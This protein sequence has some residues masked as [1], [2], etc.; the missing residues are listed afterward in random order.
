MPTADTRASI[1][2]LRALPDRNRHQRRALRAILRTQPAALQCDDLATTAHDIACGLLEARGQVL[3]AAHRGV[4][5]T[6]VGQMACQLMLKPDLVGMPA[7][8][9][10]GKT[11]SIVGFAAGLHRCGL[12]HGRPFLGKSVLITAFKIEALVEL[13]ND[14][15][16]LGVPAD[17]VGIMFDKDEFKKKD[18]IDRSGWPLPTDDP[19]RCPILLVTHNRVTGTKGD[20]DRAAPF[21]KFAG[22]DRDLVIVDE[23]LSAFRA[24]AFEAGKV[25][26]LRAA[27]EEFERNPAVK[28]C[29]DHLAAVLDRL[30][31]AET[32]EMRGERA[33]IATLPVLDPAAQ[34]EILRVVRTTADSVNVMALKKV[35][36]FSGHRVRLIF[37][38]EDADAVDNKAAVARI[39]PSVPPFP[40]VVVFD[41]S[42][43]LTQLK[44]V[45]SR[46]RLHDRWKEFMSIKD[47]S[48]LRIRWRKGSSGRSSV[49][50]RW[51]SP[52]SDKRSVEEVDEVVGFVKS[53][54][55][56][57]ACVIF[58]FKP[59]DKG[60]H[61]NVE[62][63]K[64]RLAKAD[65]VVDPAQDGGYLEVEEFDSAGILTTVRKP[66]IM[67]INWGQHTT[68]SAFKHATY[69]CL[70]SVLHLS[71]LVQL[72]S[73]VA[74]TG[75]EEV[76][77]GLL[78]E[79][80]D[81]YAAEHASCIYQAIGRSALRDTVDGKA[82]PVT[83]F[84]WHDNVDVIERLKTVFP[85]MPEHVDVTPVDATPPTADAI[86]GQK[87]VAGLQSLPTDAGRI[88]VRDFRVKFGMTDGDGVP[89]ATFRRARVAIEQN[90]S[91]HRTGW[92]RQGLS[93]VSTS[94]AAA[95]GFTSEAA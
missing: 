81:L 23:A 12:K 48:T 27:L 45:G 86:V 65:V 72:A 51:N 74:R 69:V 70:P 87:I 66:R 90:G 7:G 62:Q 78:G 76:K 16:A 64:R 55:A 14:I 79:M 21:I 54:P 3:N 22:K 42:A 13:R 43:V 20:I 84:L 15:L 77:R 91:M 82:K 53:V 37:V 59:E 41:A 92:V 24:Q 60:G 63:I 46:I 30:A 5:M 28:L 9:G 95:F 80:D 19:S 31:P 36:D 67:V 26:S 61:S 40:N 75:D 10:V 89:D 71:D 58:G 8:V 25:R 39:I 68:T 6:M 34:K 49:V 29:R 18:G 1:I 93:F 85:G 88:L 2:D 4:I 83:V 35:L 94:S 44:D 11:T 33:Y 57:A 56:D 38:K 52:A 73:V 50:K 32:A 47:Y 17:A